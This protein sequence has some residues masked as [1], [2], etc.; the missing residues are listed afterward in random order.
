MI[1][2][3]FLHLTRNNIKYLLISGQAT[4]LYGAATFSED[5]DLW[6]SPE[7]ENWKKFIDCLRKSKAKIYKVT[8]PIKFDFIQNGHGYHFEVPSTEQEDPIWFLD[9][10]GVVPRVGSFQA[11]YKNVNFCKT[12]WGKIATIGLRDLVQIKK[13]RRLTDYPIIS[14][15]VRQEY[16][17]MRASVIKDEDWVWI[18]TNS[19]ETEDIL[20]YLKNH[21]DARKVCKKLS[22]K[23]LKYALQNNFSSVSN[24]IALE[25]EKFRQQDRIYWQIIIAE[26][27][28]L[29]RKGKLLSVGS[30]PVWTF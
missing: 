3:F 25:I 21:R 8:P 17:K 28:A 11:A 16:E 23:C 26:L 29:N 20:F 10:M 27:K 22:R 13:T 18:L 4:V 24:A 30:T 1:K 7:P 14:N 6:I 19:F 5:I 15:L 12:E 9:V 2:K